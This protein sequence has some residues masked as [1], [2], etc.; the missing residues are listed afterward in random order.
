MANHLDSLIKRLR[1]K[2]YTKDLDTLARDLTDGLSAL[3]RQP[4]VARG[5]S[6][7][8]IADVQGGTSLGVG[9]PSAGNTSDYLVQNPQPGIPRNIGSGLQTRRQ[10]RIESRTRV[11]PGK[12]L[13]DANAG[14]STVNVSVIGD[15]VGKTT[16]AVTGIEVVDNL[17]SHLQ[18]SVSTINGT[19]YMAANTGLPIVSAGSSGIQPIS[20]GRTVEVVVSEQWEVTTSHIQRF[21][22]SMPTVTRVLKNR[23]AAIVNGMASVG[24]QCNPFESDRNIF[25]KMFNP[26][27]G[28]DWVYVNNIDPG[29]EG[30]AWCVIEFSRAMPDGVLNRASGDFSYYAHGVV[31]PGGTISF[32]GIPYSVPLADDHFYVVENPSGYPDPNYEYAVFV[33]CNSGQYVGFGDFAMNNSDGRP[34]KSW[35]IIDPNFPDP[36]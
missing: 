20:A 24:I 2:D 5:L 34:Q 1:S 6:D 27:D 31:G 9:D 32:T 23:T 13:T 12:V 21:R 33:G 30:K 10:T 26:A 17:T 16:D 36:L 25:E 3:S 18:D 7:G 4:E 15:G 14:D 28:I 8:T 35:T 11:L 22:K 29:D 19:E